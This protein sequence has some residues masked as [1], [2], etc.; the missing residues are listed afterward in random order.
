M[1]E[2]SIANLRASRWRE[3][4]L[5]LALPVGYS[6]VKVR[7]IQLRVDPLWRCV[8]VREKESAEFSVQHFRGNGMRRPGKEL[9]IP[10]SQTLCAA[11]TGQLPTTFELYKPR[12]P[13]LEKGL[14]R[15]DPARGLKRYKSWG[16]AP[17][18]NLEN[19]LPRPWKV[20]YSLLEI[21]AI[22]SGYISGHLSHR[23][24]YFP[25]CLHRDKPENQTCS[26]QDQRSG[27]RSKSRSK[28]SCC[29]L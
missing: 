15:Q 7:L 22:S 27:L 11:Y 3:L 18:M 9:R 29:G 19:V 8:R 4:H 2:V 6:G 13:R 23:R 28:M 26:T 17:V 24:W 14:R 21:Q 16:L 5:I 10:N 1:G 20:T 25:Q 12:I